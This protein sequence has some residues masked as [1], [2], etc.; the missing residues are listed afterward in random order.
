MAI[1]TLGIDLA[2]NVFA[3]HGV[4]A[5]AHTAL[6]R[7]CVPRAKLL[8]AVAG[9]PPCLIGME[10][11]S[12]AH[13]WA[14]LFE[15]QGHTVRL[16]APKFVSP[17]RMS[18]RRGKNDAA[19]AAA[20]CEA[21]TRPK[22]RFVP[23]KSVD[24]QGELVVHRA[25]QAFVQQRTATI[26]RIRG[27][28]SEFG[29]VLPLKASTV[30][31]EALHH[32]EDLPGWANTVINDLLSELHHLDDRVAQYDHHIQ[33]IAHESTAVK[34]LMQLPGVGPAT[35]T[36]LVAMIGRGQEFRCGR[37]LAAWLGLVPGQYSSGGKQRL[38]RITKAGDPYLRTL[39]IL[40]ARSVLAAAK[41]KSDP[42]STWAMALEKRAGY[43]KTVVA[44]AAKNARMCW[45]VLNRGESFKLPA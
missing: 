22:M 3:M 11:C 7:P 35:A 8:E 36:A 21:V 24:Q 26:N 1:V 23:V 34:Q 27:F 38:G 15:A 40:G 13:H 5:T 42:V 10:A 44:I 31:R 4:D 30:R 37:Q 41:G 39:L 20:I 14:R 25:R 9:I 12:G 45:A 43:W 2:K 28:M 18:G 19:D 6:Q 29:I 32:L 17:Y 33:V 16:M